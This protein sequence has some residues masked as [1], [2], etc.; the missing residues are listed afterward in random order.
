MDTSISFEVQFRE[1]EAWLSERIK[2]FEDEQMSKGKA[3]RDYNLYLKFKQETSSKQD[4]YDKLCAQLKMSSQTMEGK[5]A[6]LTS[7]ETK[8][9]KIGAQVVKN[10]RTA[11]YPGNFGLHNILLRYHYISSLFLLGKA[12]AMVIRHSTSR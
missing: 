10:C 6:A 5:E 7:I 4:S 1:L 3:L 2:F 12:L 11:K 8:W 9:Q